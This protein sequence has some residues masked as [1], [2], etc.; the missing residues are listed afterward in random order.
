MGGEEI[1]LIYLLLLGHSIIPDMLWGL[2]GRRSSSL[3]K[4]VLIFLPALVLSFKGHIVIFFLRSPKQGSHS[5]VLPGPVKDP[6]L[7][8]EQSAQPQPPHV[9]SSST[10]ATSRMWLCS[11]AFKVI[12]ITENLKFSLL[13]TLATFQLLRI[14]LWLVAIL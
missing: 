3:R 9:L 6:E 5:S 2:L 4:R 8:T 10:G 14:S 1:F 11:F 12:K 7:K 13:V